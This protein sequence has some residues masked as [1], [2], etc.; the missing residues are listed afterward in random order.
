MLHDTDPPALERQKGKILNSKPVRNRYKTLS[1]KIKKLK[2]NLK[3]SYMSRK[4]EGKLSIG[5]EVMSTG[6]RQ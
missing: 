3:T 5:S 1:Q 6:R 4:G 2:K